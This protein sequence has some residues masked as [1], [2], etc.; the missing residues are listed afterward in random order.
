M[1]NSKMIDAI[2]LANEF[3]SVVGALKAKPRRKLHEAHAKAAE[4]LRAIPL[5]LS[6]FSEIAYF[7]KDLAQTP[8]PAE[9]KK[10]KSLGIRLAVKKKL[11]LADILEGEGYDRITAFRGE[12]MRGSPPGVFAQRG[13]SGYALVI[14]D[15]H[16]M[17]IKDEDAV[18]VTA[19]QQFLEAFSD[20]AALVAKVSQKKITLKLADHFAVFSQGGLHGVLA[21]EAPDTVAALNAYIDTKISGSEWNPK[22]RKIVSPIRARVAQ[23]LTEKM[24]KLHKAGVLYSAGRHGWLSESDIL[25]DVAKN[26]D[27]REVYILNFSSA[28][29]QANLSATIRRND[30]RMISYLNHDD[31]AVDAK[32]LISDLASL[33]MSRRG[34]N[35]DGAANKA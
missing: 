23:L 35:L 33:E 15:K 1:L 14:V 28:K 12:K 26:D 10:A 13:G 16:D 32:K 9:K 19:T 24:S 4:E 3:T 5:T 17:D 31:E 27:V 34:F 18:K 20:L 22:N 8:S 21:F 6:F 29:L 30:L 25:I 7:L 2:E 11:L